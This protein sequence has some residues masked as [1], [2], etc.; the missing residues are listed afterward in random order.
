MKDQAN[1]SLIYDDI[2]TVGPDVHLKGGYCPSCEL[3]YFPRQDRCAGCF[4][5]VQSANLG[6][7]AVIYSVTTIRTKAP[8]GLP[9]PYSVAYVD[10]N[11]VPLRIFALLDPSNAGKYNIGQ[12]VE[13]QVAPLGLNNDQEPCLRPYFSIVN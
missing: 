5:D 2:I 4:G 9:S 13:L 6:K 10:L 11:D 7:D 3:Y 8:L 12:D 1:M